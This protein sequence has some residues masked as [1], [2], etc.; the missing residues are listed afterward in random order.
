MIDRAQIPGLVTAGVPAGAVDAH[1][2]GE[3][4]D[5]AGLP[6]FTPALCAPGRS[7]RVLALTFA[8]LAMSVADLYLT[9]LHLRTVGMIEG[10]PLARAVIELNCAWTL[11]AWKMLLVGTT[12][13]ILLATRRTR[14]AEV[15][16]WVSV[17]IMVWLM[18]Q[19]WAY[20]DSIGA[21]TP[22]LESIA[23]GKV[24]NWV[25]LEPGRK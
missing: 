9:L 12:C 16:A 24:H 15:A 8:V 23:Q 2:A 22:A 11:G 3:A 7:S 19:W 13:G 5:A 18:A 20:A 1:G 25:Q 10:N 21:L 4:T 17:G 6:V 14:S